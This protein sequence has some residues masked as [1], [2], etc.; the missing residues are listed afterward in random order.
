MAGRVT[1]IGSMLGTTLPAVV[2]PWPSQVS[3]KI[4]G[5]SLRPVWTDY[6]ATRPAKPNRDSAEKLGE[7]KTDVRS[8]TN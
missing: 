4:Q 1:V 2:I 5:S 8:S 3:L 6:P 7:D